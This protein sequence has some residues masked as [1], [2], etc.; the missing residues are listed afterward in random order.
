VF[1]VGERS[2][3]RRRQGLDCVRRKASS[4]SKSS[5]TDDAGSST[6]PDY[7]ITAPLLPLLRLESVVKDDIMLN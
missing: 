7:P 1:S 5:A 6:I 2:E 4:S 3:R